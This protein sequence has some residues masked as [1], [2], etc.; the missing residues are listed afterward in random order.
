MVITDLGTYSISS[1]GES[2]Y[3]FKVLF[4]AMMTVLGSRTKN[5]GMNG[6]Y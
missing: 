3:K 2:G 6:V 1:R 4:T 5:A